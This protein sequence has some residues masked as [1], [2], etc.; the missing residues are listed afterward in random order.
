V[1]GQSI[2]EEQARDLLIAVDAE[3]LRLYDL[4]PRRERQLLDI[5]GERDWTRCGVPFVLYR[6]FPDDFES[7]IPLHRYISE[8][9]RR[10]TAEAWRQ[11][12]KPAPDVVRR[13]MDTALD[14][15]KE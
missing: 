3:I 11:N 10:S 1:S 5:F 7:W 13:A 9:Y 15:F 8:D 4:P 6:Y 2:D 14:A 12:W